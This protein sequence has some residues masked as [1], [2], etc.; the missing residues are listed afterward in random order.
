M[1]QAQFHFHPSFSKRSTRSKGFD[2]GV[3]RGTLTIASR[4]C[5][6]HSLIFLIS[7]TQQLTLRPKIQRHFVVLWFC[8]SVMRCQVCT[9]SSSPLV[10]NNFHWLHVGEYQRRYG[11]KFIAYSL[12]VTLRYIYLVSLYLGQLIVWR[13]GESVLVCLGIFP[14]S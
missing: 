1:Y 8:A 12:Y 7:S 4:R 3:A 13:G 10:P 2:V 6:S 5:N 14:L 11:Q 9:H